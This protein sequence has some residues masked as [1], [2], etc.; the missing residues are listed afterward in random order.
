MGGGWLARRNVGDF[1]DIDDWMAWRNADVAQRS[2]AETAGREAWEQ[3]TCTGQNLTAA[4]P[5]DL[6]AIG[7]GILNQGDPAT[8]A[9]DM[10]Q[11]APAFDDPAQPGPS[12]SS[13]SAS[14][15]TASANYGIAIAK[16]GDSIAGLL[17]TSNPAAVG[18][19]ASLSGLDGRSSALYAGRSYA[20]PTRFDDASPYEVAR[21]SH[22]L[23]RDNVRLVAM[24][25]KP[26]NDTGTTERFATLVNAGINPWTGEYSARKPSVESSN[27]PPAPTIW[28]DRSR[29]AKAL[30]GE[31]ALRVG[32]AAGLA[33]GGW[34]MAQDAGSALRLL[35][36]LDPYFSPAGDAAWDHVIDAGGRVVG[37]AKKAISNP[38]AVADDIGNLARRENIALNLDATPMADTFPGELRRNFHIGANQGQAAF[39]VGSL[40]LGGEFSKG[41]SLTRAVEAAYAAKYAELGLDPK[42]ID[43]LNQPY[44][45]PGHHNIPQRFKFPEA[46]GGIPLPSRIA[47]QPLPGLVSDGAF[48]LSKPE[49]ATRG[50]MYAYHYRVDPK[51]YGG[52]LPDGSGG[53]WSGKKLGLQK[54]GLAERLWYGAPDALRTPIGNAVAGGGAADIYQDDWD[55]P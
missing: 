15:N 14:P 28:L 48:N 40:F 1:N 50:Q 43:Y 13:A 10:A 16:P 31:A 21:G 24:T 6:V 7:A 54:Y 11:A 47:G 34:H 42:V 53:G 12:P 9:P 46:V 22:L 33:R 27:K 36:P 55:H 39:D 49:G 30:A 4:Q 20:V 51:Y 35:N 2:D 41:L 38:G 3:A 25:P 17:G 45:R 18:R 23:R 52:R 8:V 32:Q 19:F 29:P 44:E 5:G 37:Y 26:A